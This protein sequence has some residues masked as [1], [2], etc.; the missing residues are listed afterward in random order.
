MK[1]F[2][3]LGALLS[4]VLSSCTSS[5]PIFAELSRNPSGVD[6]T[7]NYELANINL[8]KLDESNLDRE[9]IEKLNKELEDSYCRFYH[10][11]PDTYFR[12]ANYHIN[13]VESFL[14]T[15]VAI[16]LISAFRK[17]NKLPRFNGER[18]EN[19]DRRRIN[20]FMKLYNEALAGKLPPLPILE[21]YEFFIVAGW[22]NEGFRKS[23]FGELVN[24]LKKDF[25]VPA[26]QVHRF[27][28]S[29]LDT[30][31]NNAKSLFNEVSKHTGKG[32]SIVFVAHSMGGNVV[33]NLLLSQ[34][35]FLSKDVASAYLVQSPLKGTVT[36]GAMYGIQKVIPFV[37]EDK[38]GAYSMLAAN[39]HKTM[40]TFF[41]SMNDD[42]RVLVDRKVFYI[43]TSSNTQR[44]KLG[45]YLMKEE[46]DGTVPTGGTYFK[47]YGQRLGYLQQVGHT[48][49]F[50]QGAK[51][52][53]TPQ[54]RQAFAQTLFISFANTQEK[55]GI[56]P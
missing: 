40:K 32:R 17:A 46:N 48:D 44:T 53:L 12:D 37:E 27:F 33:L 34:P 42:V 8:S 13:S 47:T 7:V 45:T 41:D 38:T 50:L 56:L 31:E 20:A 18:I 21:S 29:S 14:Q 35:E 36:A 6:C 28:P 1:S 43:S 10:L 25:K 3:L 16:E 54:A 49:L 22:G 30:V 4:L 23:Y 9:L 2:L 51:S 15:D 39:T 26:S 11:N 52:G 5:A 19:K 55:P 24:S